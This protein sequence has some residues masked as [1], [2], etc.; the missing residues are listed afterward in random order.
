MRPNVEVPPG[1][2]SPAD[3]DL[4][5][6]GFLYRD[7]SK[8][9]ISTLGGGFSGA[10]VF[11]AR[12]WDPMGHEQA[13][14]VLKLGKRSAIA[15]ERVAFEQ[16]EAILGN[17]APSIRGFADLG[18]RAG[19]R[20]AYAA[21][22]RGK[23]RTFK[24]L[25]EGGIDE[26][27]IEDIL[28]HTFQGVLGRF[29][30]VAR[31]ERLPLF[32]YY[33]FDAR[34]HDGVARR[35]AEVIRG[36]RATEADSKHRF[37]VL[38]SRPTE[39]V[40]PGVNRGMG[41]TVGDVLEFSGGYKVPNPAGIYGDNLVDYQRVLGEFHYVSYVHGDLNGANILL[42]S[43][44]NI[45][46]IDF[47]HA[48]RGHVLRDLAKL[49]NDLLY[50][51]TPISNRIKLEEATWLTQ[52]LRQVEDLGSP[53]PEEVESVNSPAFRRAWR[54]IR[55]LREIG[56]TICG[57][58]RSPVQMSIALLRYA[59]HTLWFDEASPL[60][61]QWALAAAGGHVEDIRNAVA[62][63]R[64]LRID[65]LDGELLGGGRLGMTICPGRVDRHRSLETDL[66][67][68]VESGA[69][70]LLCLISEQEMNWVGV[71]AM[72]DMATKMG[73]EFRWEPILDQKTPSLSTMKSI[74]D[75]ILEATE[76]GQD[77]VV[78]CMGGLGRSGLVATCALV[79]RGHNEEASLE[80]VRHT[81]S[82]RAVETAEQEAF[83]GDYLTFIG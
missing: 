20:Y 31:Y 19:L 58:D 28:R 79:Q 60:Q 24:S 30:S 14:T 8:V 55:L 64:K 53:L 39:P 12:S 21:M 7:S 37:P 34:Y 1:Q 74:V 71:T 76:K 72:P 73:L 48:H 81:R 9:K 33:T 22:G 65:C 43:N 59:I 82:P 78:H 36:R 41:G 6:L 67:A 61:K 46:L 25:Y 23:V 29:Y 69:H 52:A 63:S 40:G 4:D 66:R 42:D 83:I 13:P 18:D 54:A 62:R 32:D 15:K 44:E 68:I 49:E 80:E 38:E 11:Q 16:V 3:T 51:F 27:K 10:Q 35:V 45:W 77:V 57:E 75:W 70:K 5:I 56:G 17:D 2:D 26:Q 50:I 47:F